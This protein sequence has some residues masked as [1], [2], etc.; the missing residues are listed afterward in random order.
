MKPRR[1]F[2]LLL[3]P[4]LL[5]VLGGVVMVLWNA[6]VP[7]VFG[8]RRL[9]YGQ[10]VG[11][12]V[13]CRMLFGGFHFGPRRFGP[14]FGGPAARAGKVDAHERRRTRQVQGGVA[15]AVWGVMGCWLFVA[16]CSLFGTRCFDIRHSSFN[17]RYF[18][19]LLQIRYL[20]KKAVWDKVIFR[21]VRL[22]RYQAQTAIP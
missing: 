3:I 13:L 14:P 17:I 20:K 4:V 21:V 2:F 12:L 16:G 10:A 7:D 6:V 9:T 5:A 8:W 11:L 15:Q 22:P 1:Y 18:L 19:F